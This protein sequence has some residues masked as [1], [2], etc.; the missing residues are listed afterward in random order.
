MKFF[1]LLSLLLGLQTFS[2]ASENEQITQLREMKQELIR[3]EDKINISNSILS[4]YDSVKRDPQEFHVYLLFQA[5]G[6][7]KKYSTIRPQDT[8]TANYALLIY[9]KVDQAIKKNSFDIKI[10]TEENEALK[11]NQKV[12]QKSFYE[13]K[14]KLGFELDEEFESN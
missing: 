13:L 12:K 5:A 11:R 10:I 7:H 9:R 8:E 14:R 6:F 3:I 4:L 1:I 2:H